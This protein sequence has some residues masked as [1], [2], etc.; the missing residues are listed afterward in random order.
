VEQPFVVDFY[1]EVNARLLAGVPARWID[2]GPPAQPP[3]AWL[4]VALET[5]PAAA[6]DHDLLAKLARCSIQGEAGSEFAVVTGPAHALL[7][8]ADVLAR[9]GSD[10]ARHGA[11]L[12]QAVENYLHS[13]GAPRRPLVVG[14]LNVT[15][16]SFSDGGQHL[17]PSAAVR[18]GVEMVAEGADWIDV[19]GE[20][21]RPGA[22][23]VP[24][25]EELRRVLPV[26]A[27]LAR[28]VKVPLSIDTRKAEVARRC[29][30]AGA[31][32]VNDVSALTHDPEMAAVVAAAGASVV[33]MH[34]PGDPTTMQSRTD[35][36][37]VVADTARY[38][39]QRAEAAVAAGIPP[40]RLWIDPGFGF[41]KTP[42]QNLAILRRLREYRAIGLPILV[43]TSRKSTLGRLLGGAP[44]E[45]R[46]PGTAA[47]VTAAVLAGAAAVRVHDVREIARVVS[48]AAAIAYHEV[49]A[50]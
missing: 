36:R 17:D 39:R 20:S 22:A 43:G 21:T 37:D 11:A 34:M 38:L 23:A 41:G 46:L 13:L 27:E 9:D 3:A 26:V 31:S 50:A 32:I 6:W 28:A 44:P 16:D 12:R 30:E 8:A 19:G 5:L 48:V 24:A 35:Y 10:L 4:T 45:D 29:L 40:E 47:T 1:P 25:E 18:R 42:A 49:D 2:P 33:L 15:P 14:I 7:H